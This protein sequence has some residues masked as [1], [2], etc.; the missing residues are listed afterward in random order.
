MK[1]GLFFWLMITALMLSSFVLG[2]RTEAGH[3]RDRLLETGTVV[4]EC[5][6]FGK[7]RITGTVKVL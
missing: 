1:Q 2:Q 5:G 6:D 3:I 7:I 4:V